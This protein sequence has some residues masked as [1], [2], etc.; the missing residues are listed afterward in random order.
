MM[1][2][3]V[4]TMLALC[5]AIVLFVALAQIMQW[6]DHRFAELFESFTTDAAM[7][8]GSTVNMTK[9]RHPKS[10]A[11]VNAGLKNFY[12]DGTLR[13]DMSLAFFDPTVTDNACML[14][15]PEVSSKACNSD[16]T[17]IHVLS[18]PDK[19]TIV[20]SVVDCADKV[21]PM[22]QSPKQTES[23]KIRILSG[24]YYLSK[25]CVDTKVRVAPG[26]GSI[27]VDS[28]SYA[29]RLLA[30]L[31]PT[32]LLLPQAKLSA[33]GYFPAHPNTIGMFD[34]ASRQAF[35]L[36]LSPVNDPWVWNTGGLRPDQAVKAMLSSNEN[37]AMTPGGLSDEV[38]QNEVVTSLTLYYPSFSEN[39]HTV[40]TDRAGAAVHNV[41]TLYFNSNTLP[42]N[43][44]LFSLRKSGGQT[45]EVS[46]MP[47]SADGAVI[48]VQTGS[49]WD[50][51]QLIPAP[52]NAMILVTY[53]CNLL[54]LVCL[55]KSRIVVKHFP[56]QPTLSCNNAGVTAALTSASPPNI[57]AP[58]YNNTC[59]PN[60]ADIAVRL[61]VLV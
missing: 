42:R 6:R 49:R 60:Y 47:D 1:T 48:R 50:A 16:F 45:F 11:Y 52:R 43:G 44:E 3:R 51:N 24:F 8:A 30:L 12:S 23:A 14:G 35:E 17:Q 38:L 59:I 19:L 34:T 58:P 4:K 29:G 25:V 18:V 21:F 5:V 53:T 46:S 26:G 57:V 37:V 2:P 54:I 9:A 28:A 22:S 56:N 33:V 32:F 15:S 20:D 41:L 10:A 36:P 40:P 27:S 7:L 31:R 39:V 61:G 55:S 13:T